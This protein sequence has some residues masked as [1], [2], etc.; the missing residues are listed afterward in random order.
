MAEKDMTEKMLEDYNDVDLFHRISALMKSLG[1]I[2]WCPPA[3]T[4]SLLKNV[5]DAKLVKDLAK[6]RRF[7]KVCRRTPNV[8][9]LFT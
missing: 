7:L 2:I 3:D 8:A 6:H 5:A 4:L 9:P 1:S